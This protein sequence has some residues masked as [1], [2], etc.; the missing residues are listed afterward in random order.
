MRRHK[1]FKN[2]IH[3]K[4]RLRKLMTR[5]KV[6]EDRNIRRCDFGLCGRDY[7]SLWSPGT[8][9]LSQ[10]LVWRLRLWGQPRLPQ[11]GAPSHEKSLRNEHC[12]LKDGAC[13][14]THR[15]VQPQG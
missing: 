2:H 11:E 8:S 12:S 14:H 3:L 5:Q 9:R 6:L 10:I 4:S 15:M 13:V 7:G 1:K